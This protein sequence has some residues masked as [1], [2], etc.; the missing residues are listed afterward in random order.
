M[1]SNR[2]RGVSSVVGAIFF[3]LIMIVA[4]GSLVTIFNAFTS[5]NSQVTD[6]QAAAL[7]SQE[8]SLAF[9]GFQFGSPGAPST[10]VTPAAASSLAFDGSTGALTE[11]SSVSASLTTSSSND[12][13]ILSAGTSSPA[14]SVSS[15]VDSA[16]LAWTHRATETGPTSVEMEE[17]YAVASS[18]LTSDSIT[19]SW[20]GSG[21]N[22]FEAFAISGADISSPFD[23]NPAL[24]A[25]ATGTG[26][27]PS[28]TISTSNANDIVFGLL[29]NEHQSAFCHTETTGG[30]FTDTGAAQSC[31]LGSGSSQNSDQEYRI[32]TSTQTNLAASFTTSNGGSNEWAMIGD[33]VVQSPAEGSTTSDAMAFT[34]Q[35]KLLYSGGLWW[36][37]YSTGTNIDCQTS[38][39]GLSWSAPS[40]FVAGSSSVGGSHGYDYSA[41]L[42]GASTIY[43]AIA[44]NGG[45][46]NNHFNWRYGTLSSAGCDSVD[47]AIPQT[48]VTTTNAAQGPLSVMTDSG[49]NTWVALTTLAGSTY[50][51]EVWR[52]A[53]AAAPDTWVKEDD[54]AGG[55]T[56]SLGIVSPYDCGVSS[57]CAVLVYGTALVTGP[58]DV[59]STSCSP[60]CSTWTTPVAT[61]SDYALGSSSA[62]VVGGTVYFAGLASA[63]ANQGTGTLKFWSFPLG[64]GSAPVETTIESGTSAWQAALSSS[65]GTL[66]LFE[67]ASGSTIEYRETVTYGD[68]WYPSV[69]SGPIAVSSSETSAGWLTAAG[70]GTF[71]ASWSN[72]ASSPFGF[73]YASLSMLS[74][75][76]N[77]PFAVHLVGAYVYEPSTNTLVAHYDVISSGAGVATD[78]LFDYWVGQGSRVDVP[79]AFNTFDWGANTTYMLTVSTDTGVVLSEI[80]TS[81]A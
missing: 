22:T 23:P 57:G 54:A 63:S 46:G 71:A 35:Q 77:S 59:T 74:V 11:S 30:G 37:F 76:D 31:A 18:P 38:S 24:P 72:G 43:Y 58:T 40:T 16:S 73:R 26:N 20:S 79:L 66:V 61:T 19:V 51:Q 39:D 13:I 41:W 17:W 60:S 21:D 56:E 10:V 69:T 75:V 9:D 70:T 34:S 55:T 25:V 7:K 27:N 53:S 15:I 28:V 64:S 67:K 49:G 48:Q 5:Y 52:H 14:A 50:H 32:V 68:T 81:P 12:V 29:A 33:A 3:V 44:P 4:I 2:R 6:A 42:S 65:S 45:G 1:A 47:W 36:E 78:G 80:V 8:T 62:R